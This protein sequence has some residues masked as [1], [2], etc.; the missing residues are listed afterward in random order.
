MA[1]YPKMN[2]EIREK[3]NDFFL[4]YNEELFDLLDKKLAWEN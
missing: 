2:Q 3:M 4:K 1:K